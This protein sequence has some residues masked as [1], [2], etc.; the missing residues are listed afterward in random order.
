MIR[1]LLIKLDNMQAD[2]LKKMMN[3]FEISKEEIALVKYP[4][5]I[6]LEEKHGV[7]MGT[8]YHSDKQ[9]AVFI[10]CIGVLGY[11]IICQKLNSLVF[12]TD[13]STHAS[14]IEREAVF[15][16]YFDASPPHQTKVKVCHAFVSRA[17]RVG[18]FISLTH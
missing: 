10:D 1:N 8:N 17:E 5:L 14:T 9:C 3:K 18:L 15:V 12:L 2:E 7:E 11:K 16:I 6:E 13:G 4:A